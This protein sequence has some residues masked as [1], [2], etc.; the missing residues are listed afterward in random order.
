M[1]NQ[2]DAPY[3]L[4]VDHLAA[5]ASDIKEVLVN[6]SSIECPA[7]PADYTC[8]QMLTINKEEMKKKICEYETVIAGQMA[9]VPETE[10]AQTRCGAMKVLQQNVK[11]DDDQTS[12]AENLAIVLGKDCQCHKQIT[13]I[14]QKTQQ[15]EQVFL[16]IKSVVPTNVKYIVADGANMDLMSSQQ[17]SKEEISA[18]IKSCPA[19]TNAGKTTTATAA[20]AAYKQ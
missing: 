1:T 15:P 2:H 7:K 10:K 18:M 16:L 14:N 19:N 11:S 17:I 6:A 20:A 9:L 12:I 4:L 8:P 5:A 13:S 3:Q